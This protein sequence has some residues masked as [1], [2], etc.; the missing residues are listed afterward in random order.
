MHN[1]SPT[2]D[3]PVICLN[4]TELDSITRFIEESIGSFIK[5]DIGRMLG[6]TSPT[7]PTTACKH[8]TTTCTTSGVAKSA[9][10]YPLVVIVLLCV[11]L[12]VY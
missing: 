1:I 4:Q 2:G 7:P 3:N 6:I 9:L 8:V 11:C 5:Q 10:V 12:A